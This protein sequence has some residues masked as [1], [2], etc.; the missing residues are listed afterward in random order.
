MEP[1]AAGDPLQ[2]G[3]YRLH[4]RLGAGG[5]GEVFLGYSPAGRAVAVKVIRSELARDPVFRTRFRR[6]VAAAS[7][8]SGAYTAPVTAAGPD[9]DPPWLATVFVPGPSLAEA[10]AAAGPLPAASVWKLAAGLAEALQAV[11]AC[12]LVH[13]DLKPAN[14]LL[15]I[16]GPRVI[17][18]GISHALES[19][20]MTS[21]GQLVGTPSFMSPE[22]A[23]GARAG[24]ASDVFSLGCVI[25]FAATGVGPFGNGPQASALY[26]VVHTAPALAGVTGPLRELAAACLAKVAADRPSL[27]ALV[28][29]ITASR[30]PDEGAAL[31]SFWPVPVTGLILS[32]QAR[33][34]T[35][36]ADVPTRARAM[37][38]AAGVPAAPGVMALGVTALG[39][40]GLGVPV[41]GVTR[42]GTAVPG[43]ADA[44][45]PGV[46]TRNSETAAAGVISGTRVS[47]APADRP[48]IAATSPAGAGNGMPVGPPPL[49]GPAL[50]ADA[51]MAGTS[52]GRPG[53]GVTRR[54][55][56]LGLAAAVGAGLAGAGWELSQGSAQRGRSSVGQQG[57]SGPASEP[58]SQ[59]S[60]AGR[61]AA[62]PHGLMLWS[63]ATR[64]QLAGIALAGRALFAGST[65]SSV[66]ALRVHDGGKLWE[67][68]T[69]GPVQS[70]IA[71]AGGTVYA[72]SADGKVYALR[73]RDGGKLWEFP[74]AAPA[75]A[76]IVVAAGTAYVSSEDENLYALRA[77]DGGKRWSAA[78]GAG[79]IAVAGGSVFAASGYGT[80]VALRAR[81]G[82]KL[83]DFPATGTPRGI[84]VAADTVY[85]GAGDEVSALRAG[86]G[87]RTWTFTAGGLVESGI[88]VAGAVVYV[89]GNDDMVHALRAATGA[90]IWSFRAGGPVA[91]GIAVA[92]G[93]V[94]FGT[95]DYTVHALHAGDGTSLWDFA[96]GGPVESAIVA[97]GR[98][99]YAGSND[100]KVYALRA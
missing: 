96:T 80:V 26:R 88:S 15:A 98:T 83:W 30:A 81:D 79:E 87:A 61:P 24:P 63:F 86:T 55:V 40:P 28:A 31:A 13:R 53:S 56:L 35:Q 8:V 32:H 64:G 51:V 58:A 75:A 77:A 68:R 22:Q 16:D 48:T 45:G 54:R 50:P 67:F 73:A 84:A 37:A 25:V 14:V 57:P 91:S 90:R 95:N 1:L 99:A 94:Y 78:I 82:G 65:D 66:Y 18:F 46:P 43:T 9:D 23:V 69:G 36:L 29:A 3:T 60:P 42:L 19:T 93:I 41:L 2:L 11:H 72:G 76:G 10:V 4:G 39:D 20:A 71:V 21:T 12:G 17:D 38:Q 44:Q 70:Q 85:V 52:G 59:A 89:G 47:P 33:I 92:D 27:P 49:A 97:A 6:E 5:M 100:T 34:S 62:Q 7:S 74:A